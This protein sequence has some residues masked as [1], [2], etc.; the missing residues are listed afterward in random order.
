MKLPISALKTNYQ[1]LLYFAD[2]SNYVA[3]DPI[4]LKTLKDLKLGQRI[5]DLKL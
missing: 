5:V 1:C 3:S 4:P 2:F